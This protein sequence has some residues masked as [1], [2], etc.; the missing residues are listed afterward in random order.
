MMLAGMAVTATLHAQ[1][2]L[3][4]SWSFV[5]SPP[6]GWTTSGTSVYTG[7]GNTPPAGKFDSSGDYLEIFFA[8]APGQLTYFLTGNSFSGGTFTVE[9]SVNG[10]VWTALHTFTNPP[11]A[12]YTQFTDTP[13][14]NSRYIRFYYTNKVSGNI[15][16]DDINLAVAAAG[17]AQEI[18]VVFNSATVINNG[19]VAFSGPVSSTTPVSFT[20]ENQGTATPLNITSVTISGTNASDFVVSST[21]SSIAASSSGSLVVDFTPSQA[22]TRQALLTIANDDANENPYVINLNGIGGSYASE[23]TASAT[24][25]TSSNVK[26]YRFTA[27]YTAASPAP[28][29]YLVLR[30][31]GAPVSG[32]PADG[33][34]YTRGDAIGNAKVVYMGPGTSVVPSNVVAN[35]TYH[36]AVFS[37]NG[38]GQ[39]TNYY[40]AAPLTGTVTSSG[41]MMGSY[42]SGINPS[43]ATFVSDLHN[44]INPHTQIYYSNYGPTMIDLFTARDTSNGQR[45][46]TCVY[47]GLQYV[48]TIPFDWSVMSRE[49]T[50]AHSWMPT[51]PA[52]GLKEY[53]DQHNLFPTHL[54]NANTPRS[55]YPFGEVVNA[56]YTFMGCQLGTDVNGKTVFEPRE[57]QKGDVARALM[58]MAV[59]YN[60]VSG[61]D[62]SFPNPIS[63]S[64]PYGQNQ[65]V[66]KMWH[67]QDPPDAYEI[68]RNDFLDSLQGNRNPFVDNV[69]Y[70]CYIDF[71]TMNYISNPGLPCSTSSIGINEEAANN[72]L[73]IYPNPAENTFN[74]SYSTGNNEEAVVRM[75]DVTGRVVYEK[76][77]AGSKGMNYSMHDVSGISAGV[78]TVEVKIGNSIRKEK[79]IIQ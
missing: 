47:S 59:S 33:S 54:A 40:Q 27:S 22:G 21:P 8:D 55:N 23:P 43:S 50:Y 53:D 76:R 70:A 71:Y 66:L 64:I 13:D 3:P 2:T 36:F 37:Y 24:N 31:E 78:Y 41:N 25:F 51:N 29:G 17:P 14:P 52:S 15:G 44:L 77:I 42:Y 7:S 4:T 45:V 65:N 73:D 67:Y 46:V 38:T 32:A 79:L 12:T 20:I 35:T 16:V 69:D 28:D 39:Y 18:N 56:T 9:E 60:G 61:N 5:G 68:A 11:A 48:Y 72:M 62:W 34:I 10:T 1:T 49:H 26:S 30:S 75:L 6:V 74:L 58:Y 19:S 57:S 63:A